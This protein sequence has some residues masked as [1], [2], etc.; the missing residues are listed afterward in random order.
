MCYTHGLCSKKDTTM[1][2]TVWCVPG[3][4]D[5]GVVPEPEPVVLLHGC[6]G[7]Q[8]RSYISRVVWPPPV[9]MARDRNKT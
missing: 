5:I 2:L 8:V 1:S 4:S 7:H 6:Y 3:N 9:C